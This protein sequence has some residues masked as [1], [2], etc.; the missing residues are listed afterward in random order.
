ML[1]EKQLGQKHLAEFV[2]K[3]KAS[4]G[5]N[6]VCVVVY[7]SAASDEFHSEFSDVNLLCV[8]RELSSQHLQALAPAIAWWAA[9]RF[10]AP[11]VFSR[12]EIERA[13]DVFPIEML[14]I[15][16]QHHILHGE[17]IFQGLN[18]PLDRHRFQLEHELRTKLLFLRQHYL[19]W[20]TD[21][22]KVRL[23]MLDSVANF[24]T[25]FRHT[26]LTRG[27]KPPRTKNEVI[28]QLALNIQFDPSP[29]LELLQV[30]QGKA[31]AESLDAQAIF[32]R[33]LQGIQKVIE[34]V[35]AM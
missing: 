4:S 19:A 1:K 32:A 25:L 15:K 10:P 14:D 3:L 28:E 6:L 33:Y 12:Q 8:V 34:A 11:L 16:Q 5:N 21:N 2:E 26:L 17:D 7:G 18:V 22:Q 13:A 24:A 30:R 20:C 35:D 31:Q 9:N 29:F 23:L 27:E